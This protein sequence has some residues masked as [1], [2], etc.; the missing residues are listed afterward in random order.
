M[1]DFLQLFSR[2]CTRDKIA[3]KWNNEYKPTDKVWRETL[4]FWFYCSFSIQE[5][6]DVRSSS[7]SIEPFHHVPDETKELTG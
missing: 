2:F 6:C 4:E 7:K 1:Y 5:V 3:W